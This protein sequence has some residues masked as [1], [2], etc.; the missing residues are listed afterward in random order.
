MADSLKTGFC[1]ADRHVLNGHY[2]ALSKAGRPKHPDKKYVTKDVFE[3]S[4]IK[5]I[6]V[7]I[8]D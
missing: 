4:T 7:L 6:N 2:F 3:I 1:P 5:K 8:H